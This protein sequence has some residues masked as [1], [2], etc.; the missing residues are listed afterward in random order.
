MSDQVMHCL[1]L[2]V[3]KQAPCKTKMANNTNVD[4]VGVIKA[5]KVKTLGTEVIVDIFV[6]PTKGEG[7]FMILGRPWLMAM[8]AKQDWSIGVIRL[9]GPKGKGIHYNMKTRK[10]QEL[11]L[12]VLEDEFSSN[13][14][15]RFEEESSTSESGDDSMEIIGIILGN[16][17][18]DIVRKPRH[19]P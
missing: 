9:Q 3:D 7:Y 14:T 11:D 15:S 4:C 10:Q 2:A 18:K 1:G 13:T 19:I 5:L 12:E 17:N 16:S 8:K 6:M